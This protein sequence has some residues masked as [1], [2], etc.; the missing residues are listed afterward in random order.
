MSAICILVLSTKLK[1]V[2][3]NFGLTCDLCSDLIFIYYI[4]SDS[5]IMWYNVDGTNAAG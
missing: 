3:S 4:F 1:G 2:P 5:I